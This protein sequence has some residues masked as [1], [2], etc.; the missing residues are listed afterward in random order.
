MAKNKEITVIIDKLVDNAI[1]KYG[2]ESKKTIQIVKNAEK[3][4]AK[5]EQ[6]LIKLF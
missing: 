5:Y 6:N 1:K 3:M 2:L 4:K